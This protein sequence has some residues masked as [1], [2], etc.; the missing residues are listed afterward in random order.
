MG[1]AAYLA[2]RR[3][4]YPEVGSP[5]GSAAQGANGFVTVPCRDEPWL[6][7]TGDTA[8]FA[9]LMEKRYSP[10][11]AGYDA[12]MPAGPEVAVIDPRAGTA[13]GA[14]DML[15][16]STGAGLRYRVSFRV[17]DESGRANLNVGNPD[18]MASGPMGWYLTS[19]SLYDANVC[20]DNPFQTR[21]IHGGSNTNIW[22]R[23]PGST[24]DFSTWQATVLRFEAPNMAATDPVV[25]L[26]D[27][28][29][30]LELRSNGLRGGGE[31]VRAADSNSPT[32]MYQT[33]AAGSPLRQFFTTNSVSRDFS[34]LPGTHA[35]YTVGTASVLNYPR[36]VCINIPTPLTA[37][38]AANAAAVGTNLASTMEQCGY[39]AQEAR[40]MAIN[41]VA[42]KVGSG[43]LS[44]PSRG[45]WL[46]NGPSF[47][48]GAGLKVRM[49][50][51]MIDFS[52]VNNL[53]ADVPGS[54]YIGLNAQPFINELV[55]RVDP[56]KGASP[57][58]Y[59]VELANPYPFAID[60]AGIA[61]DPNSAWSLEIRDENQKVLAT[62]SLA[63][64]TGGKIAAGGFYVVTLGQALL[65]ET[66]GSGKHS[67]AALTL[68]AKGAVLLK[69]P[70]K[71]TDGSAHFD[72]AATV[73][74]FGYGNP[75]YGAPAK[76]TNYSLQRD[77][78]DLWMCAI[79]LF[80]S[81]ISGPCGV[82][83]GDD[84][85]GTAT[86]GIYP[87]HTL[88]Q[89][90]VVSAYYYMPGTNPAVVFKFFDRAPGAAD[91]YGIPFVA[92]VNNSLFD[93][94]DFNRIPRV[95]NIQLG[96]S[97]SALSA[98]LESMKSRLNDPPE[99][100]DL[101][102]WE[103]KVRFDFRGHADP[104]LMNDPRAVAV[105]ESLSMLDRFA[106]T[107][108]AH[109]EPGDPQGRYRTRIPGRINLNTAAVQVLKTVPA[110]EVVPGLADA[111]V[112]YRDRTGIFGLGDYPG[113]G[114]RSQTELYEPL[115]AVMPLSTTSLEERDRV[116]SELLVNTTVRSDTF[117]VYGLVEALSPGADHD[118]SD[119]EWYDAGNGHQTV[120]AR[121]RFL[122]LVDRSFQNYGPGENGSGVPR[123]LAVKD[124]AD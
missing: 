93:F 3:H 95:A 99:P 61:G 43:D 24:M 28:T 23:A 56:S 1:A 74:R 4:D 52:G 124:L 42:Y 109:V 71:L 111:I 16:F 84:S 76:V 83:A 13:D 115:S 50:T 107:G 10:A 36:A 20:V 91:A 66:A 75:L 85:A 121:R 73:D 44:S 26:F 9:R 88:G 62:V 5:F 80:N 54:A 113:K 90:N 49:R 92:D 18:Y 108:Y 98:Q 29:D 51:G 53:H 102:Y 77:N 68:P 17:E 94:A 30:E 116:W 64:A 100:L 38:G 33:L 15:P 105:F 69:R 120:V 27:L 35:G 106:D 47:L 123:I 67:D 19:Y 86:A 21:N 14:Y 81:A 41:Y 12:A 48:D 2:A 114:I 65:D 39:S 101:T 31:F 46:A 117:V 103:S 45:Y 7:Q 25:A 22:G 8:H 97:G 60:L 58:D 70:V 34:P 119:A 55:A 63:K 96:T 112:A 89:K 78:A 110:I 72:G 11:T 6:V 59:A 37:Q 82:I 32:F 104:W 79:N 118:N 122:A 87:G 57:V 40:S